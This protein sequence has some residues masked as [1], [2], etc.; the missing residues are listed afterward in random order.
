[1]AER[2]IHEKYI[3]SRYSDAHMGNIIFPKHG[4]HEVL[5]TWLKKPMGMVIF[6]GCPGCGKTYTSVAMTRFLYDLASKSRIHPEVYFYPQS[7]LFD[8]FRELYSNNWTDISLK[9]RISN[10]LVLTIDDFGSQRN[11]E[12][13]I[14]I[15]TQ[16]IES[17]YN[18]KRPTIISS[19][20]GFHEIEEIFH[21][22]V[23]SRL[24]ATENLIFTDWKTDLRRSDL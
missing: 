7:K 3:D 21:P 13:Q 14:E 16:V 20:L 8:E 5:N 15:M 17:R 19:N 6:L 22:R 4:D 12:W 11:N 9:E 23:R 10:S 18:S 24:E 2:K 1:M